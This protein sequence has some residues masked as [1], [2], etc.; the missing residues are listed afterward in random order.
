MGLESCW[1]QHV[2]LIRDTD[3]SARN[4]VLS[5]LDTELPQ[6]WERS[7]QDGVM[8]LS[9]YPFYKKKKMYLALIKNLKL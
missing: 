6:N 8:C 9:H 1:Q 5:S 2:L 4:T 7:L 3:T